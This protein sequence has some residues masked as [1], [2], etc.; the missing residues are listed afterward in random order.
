MQ[1]MTAT[2]S[3]ASPLVNFIYLTSCLDVNLLFCSV[4]SFVFYESTAGTMT[5]DSYQRIYCYP[6]LLHIPMKIFQ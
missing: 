4:S 1:K 2:A 3:P 6:I 5:V